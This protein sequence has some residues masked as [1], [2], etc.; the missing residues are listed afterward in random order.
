M[1]F[2][3]WLLFAVATLIFWGTTGVAQKLS[4]NAVSTE[5]LFL[6]WSLRS[7]PSPS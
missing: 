7:S 3:L 4:T 2:P 6:W 5:L 1:N